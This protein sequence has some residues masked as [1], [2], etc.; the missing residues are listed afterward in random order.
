MTLELLHDNPIR[1]SLGVLGAG[2]NKNR[3]KKSVTVEGRKGDEK[4]E[5][6]VK[7][8]RLRERGN[9]LAPSG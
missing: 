9:D 3:Y 1:K 5:S 6:R 2:T 8:K 7:A 4:R